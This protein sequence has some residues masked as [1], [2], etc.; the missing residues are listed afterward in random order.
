MATKS[1]FGDGTLVG[2][3]P[4]TTIEPSD[5]RPRFW[6]KPLAMATKFAFGCGTGSGPCEFHMTIEPSDF[7]PTPLR[8]PAA[9]AM[10]PVFA[11]GGNRPC[12]HP[13]IDPSDFKPK[14]VD[15]SAAIAMNPE[16][17]AGTL[18]SP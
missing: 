15:S 17:G 12:P 6:Y 1:E 8:S 13:T 18:H 16:F 9:T 14:L 7:K 2:A 10:N 5:F 3:P 4:S 11:P